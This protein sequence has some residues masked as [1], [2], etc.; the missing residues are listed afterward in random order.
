MVPP[1]N[2]CRASIPRFLGIHFSQHSYCAPTLAM[3][4]KCHNPRCS[5]EFRYFGDGKLF[6]FT[7]DSIRESSQLYWLCDRCNQTHS[8]QRDG[9]GEVRLVA[10]APDGMPSSV[11]DPRFQRAG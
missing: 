7:P 8:L 3:V 5:A 4:S 2:R 6:E 11:R 9:D 10:K 1:T